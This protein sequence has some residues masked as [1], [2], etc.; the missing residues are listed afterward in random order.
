MASNG[1]HDLMAIVGIG[2]SFMVM[3]HHVD[4]RTPRGRRRTRHALAV[5]LGA[6][7]LAWTASARAQ[8]PAAPAPAP[9]APYPGVPLS[10]TLP[11]WPEPP[12]HLLTPEEPLPMGDP[13]L[14]RRVVPGLADGMAPLT[15]FLRDTALSLRLRTFYFNRLNPDGTENE[16]WAF[17]GWLAYQSGWL[18]D[19]FAIGTVGYTALPLYAPDGKPGTLLLQPPDDS[20]FVLGQVYG[21]LRYKE[22]A[23]L[24]GG[25]LLVDDGYV[26]PNDS[27]MVPNTFEGATLTGQIGPVGYN[28]AYLTA[29]KPRQEED[30]QNMAEIAGVQDRNRGL[31]L[32]RL[33]AEPLPGLSLYAANY[34]V[35]DVFNTAY[36]NADYRHALADDLAFRIGI[37]YTDQRSTGDEFL[38]DFQT[39]NFGLRADLLWRGL[40]MGAA[41]G[42]TGDDARLRTPYGA[43]PGY[44]AFMETDFNRADEKAWGVGIR[45]DFNTGTLLPSLQ[46]SGLVVFMRY[47]EGYDAVDPATNR[48][49]PT[50][51]EGNFDVIWNLP[52]VQG[53]QFRFRTAY[54]DRGVGRVQQAYRIIVN[55]DLPLL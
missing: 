44:L 23:L 29:M 8:A 42:V 33:A 3:R 46:R 35:P 15:P 4:A 45:Y 13:P 36:G 25:R 53:L 27:R 40:T 31:V 32:T 43:W 12:E 17:G 24:T 14:L 5:A 1:M 2:L 16:A 50:N 22:Y 18:L 34:L 51:R 20:I 19:T 48:G 37:Q 54:T 6:L 47:A 10:A 26:N 7:L 49:L 30:F 28:V 38:D 11:Y 21:Q 41:F 52:W 55:Y 9:E 39:W